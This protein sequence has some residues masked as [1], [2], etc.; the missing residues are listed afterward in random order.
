[1]SYSR[2]WL[3]KSGLIRC[4]RAGSIT[5]DTLN[6]VAEHLDRACDYIQGAYP[7]IGSLELRTT[8][9]STGYYGARA[10][11]GSF[12]HFAGEQRAYCTI[13]TAVHTKQHQNHPR[14]HLD[15]TRS[16]LKSII[17]CVAY[18]ASA[19]EGHPYSLRYAKELCLSQGDA[20]IDRW[21]DPLY[22]FAGGYKPIH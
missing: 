19:L 20:M 10:V 3:N 16:M 8:Y 9:R 4:Y 21:M 12:I 5:A 22:A 6:R 13:N 2:V 15:I 17:W 1:M 18:Q 11:S 7:H 14:D